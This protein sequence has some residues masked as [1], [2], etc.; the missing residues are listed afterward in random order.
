[1][2]M[3]NEYSLRGPVAVAGPFLWQSGNCG[4]CQLTIFIA[5]DFARIYATIQGHRELE[6]ER[7]FLANWANGGNV[8]ECFSDSIWFSAQEVPL[9]MSPVCGT[10][11]P[12][13]ALLFH[14]LSM[15][16]MRSNLGSHRCL[17]RGWS[18]SLTFLCTAYHFDE[19]TGMVAYLWILE[20]T[21]SGL[22]V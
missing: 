13:G 17:S 1:M 7:G 10:R 11:Y 18:G 2:R 21:G 12:Y 3:C 14:A 20:H 16:K 15:W 6:R 8:T 5:I 9:I 19:W 4:S 22:L